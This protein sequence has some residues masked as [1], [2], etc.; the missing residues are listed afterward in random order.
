MA[1]FL[2]IARG[3]LPETWMPEGY[4][5]PASKALLTWVPELGRPAT[6]TQAAQAPGREGLLGSRP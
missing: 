2:E 6:P 4:V 5:Q 1:F 3:P